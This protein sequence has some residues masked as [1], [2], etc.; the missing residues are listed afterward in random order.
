MHIQSYSYIFICSIM[1]I[2][3]HIYRYIERIKDVC[4]FFRHHIQTWMC[5]L[6][7]TGTD[8]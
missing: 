7:L 3:I 1:Y 8:W 4:C 6:N 2:L 5:C